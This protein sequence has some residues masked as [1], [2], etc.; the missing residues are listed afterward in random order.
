[1]EETKHVVPEPLINKKEEE[2][3]K[4]L[5]ER[6]EKLT[7]PTVLAKAGK[8]VGELMPTAVKKAG[9]VAKETVTEAELFRQCMKVVADG[10]GIIEK[11]AAKYTVSEAAIVKKINAI[12]ENNEITC[13]D[14][15]CLARGYD[16][17]R[18]VSK[19]KTKDLALALLEGGTTGAFGFAGLPFNL[20]FSTFLYYRAVQSVAMFYGYDVKNDSAELVIAGDVF[21]NALSPNSQGVNEVSNII[22]KI[23]V[24][25][26]ITAVK[27]VT[28]K[29]WEEIIKRGGVGL[30]LAQMRALANKA[31]QKALEKAGQKGLEESVF[32]SVFE[33][34]GKK[35]SKKAIG[36][37]VPVVGAVIGGL[38]DTAQMNTVIDYADIFYNKRFLLE[39]G[40]RINSLFE[41]GDDVIDVEF[42]NIDDVEECE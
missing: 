1:M 29:S 39:K 7:K 24:M 16:V 32:K 20:V 37:A 17:A 36:K 21:M 40:V 28:K 27:Q 26:E 38:F 12:T 31:A 3:L 41:D 33:Q 13:I 9:K 4:K 8:K 22:A 6:Y 14:E 34:I 25:S 19:Y 30:L 2:S 5:T 23:M 35:L 18:I 10:F 42:E 11:N 15:I